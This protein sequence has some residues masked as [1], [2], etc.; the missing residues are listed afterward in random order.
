MTS[1]LVISGLA[2]VSK[3]DPEIFLQALALLGIKPSRDV[4][5]AGDNPTADIGGAHAVGLSTAW[6]RRGREWSEASFAP[7]YQVDHV[8][9]LA[10]MFG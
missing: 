8:S 6:V 10:G 5:F 9:E 1:C 2:G 4:L 7:D 3:P